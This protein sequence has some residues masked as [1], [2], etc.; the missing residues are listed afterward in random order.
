[1]FLDKCDAFSALGRL[2]IVRCAD[3]R[4]ADRI[5]TSNGMK[6]AE[7]YLYESAA[8]QILEATNASL[9]EGNGRY[10]I[11]DNEEALAHNTFFGLYR[12]IHNYM[13]KMKHSV[14]KVSI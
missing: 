12:S 7:E 5:I 9:N 13:H 10:K 11:D 3:Y 8:R 14:N 6:P 2:Y 4:K 1:M